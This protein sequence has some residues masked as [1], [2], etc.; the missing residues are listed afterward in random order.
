M[1]VYKYLFF[2][3][4]EW[5]I[6]EISDFHVIKIAKNVQNIFYELREQ[7]PRLHQK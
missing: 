5:F 4:E 2:P 1:I 7:N 3:C 6:D